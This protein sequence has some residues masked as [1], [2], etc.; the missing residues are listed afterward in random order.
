[1][2]R[3]CAEQADVSG[4]PDCSKTARRGRGGG[5]QGGAEKEDERQADEEDEEGEEELWRT[6]HT[7]NVFAHEQ[8]PTSASRQR[9]RSNSAPLVG[10]A[11]QAA[12]VERGLD[13]NDVL[14]VRFVFVF[15]RSVFGSLLVQNEFET[16]TATSSL[17][18]G[19][20]VN[21]LRPA[22]ATL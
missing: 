14:R 21:R 15:I 3:R 10:R 20:S 12:G 8:R 16:K 22:S 1:M 17:R 5:E 4:R 13:L 19:I 2:H 18:L 11:Q 7:P 9:C 6:D